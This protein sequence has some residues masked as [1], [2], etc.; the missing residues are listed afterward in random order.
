MLTCYIIIFIKQTW[1]SYVKSLEW[2]KNKRATINPKNDDD[3]CFQYAITVVLNRR[4]IENNAQRI[5]NIKPFINQY[6]WKGID[7]SSHSKDWKKFEQNNK[8]IALNILYVP[9][10]TKQIRLAYKSKYNCMRGNQ[11]ILLMIT[12]GEK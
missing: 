7:F 6:N 12:D 4:K 3:N 8:T 9:C 11:L 10:N 2:L 5:S 1:K